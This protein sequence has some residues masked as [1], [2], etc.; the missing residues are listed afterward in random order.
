V[1]DSSIFEFIRDPGQIISACQLARQSMVSRSQFVQSYPQR[2]KRIHIG[3]PIHQDLP[4]TRW[5][6]N[7]AFTL[8]RGLAL[9]NKVPLNYRW[10]SASTANDFPLAHSLRDS[11][12]LKGIA[13]Y[14]E[15][16]LDWPERI[17]IDNVLAAERLG[18]KVRN[19]TAVT[20]MMQENGQW[21]VALR[22]RESTGDEPNVTVKGRVII[23]LSG[24]SIDE[25]N[26]TVSQGSPLRRVA[27]T[28]GTHIAVRLPTEFASFGI[29]TTNRQ[30]QLFFCL[31]W[32]GLHYFGP[33]ETSHDLSHDCMR[34]TETEIEFLLSEANH[35]FPGFS[36]SR[37]DVIYAWSGVRP[38]TYSPHDA[39][40]LRA[41][42]LHDFEQEGLP[43]VIALTGGRILTQQ[44]AGVQILKAVAG[45]I[46]PSRNPPN[47]K[48]RHPSLRDQGMDHSSEY[49]SS[50][51][52]EESI[53]NATLNEHVHTL[54]D[55]LFRRLGIG[56]NEDMSLRNLESIARLVSN[57]LSWS[58]ERTRQ[59]MQNYREDV[60]NNHLHRDLT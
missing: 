36:L 24:I 11:S 44:V 18:A 25:L 37:A 4:Y 35:L 46:R 33:T 59:E 16:Q 19:Y 5:Q 34:P 57:L 20:R 48:P 13:T 53:R 30:G 3:I 42:K 6:V 31:P 41:S 26:R 39:I 10:L 2:T 32:R 50:N 40:G 58:E 55:L 60:R 56:W 47:N 29:A 43:N 1:P 54:D 8:L 7:S 23:N 49:T 14:S 21:N 28:K 12:Q 45:R 38:L 22:G 15:F 51:L 52:P 17:A 9:G 27:C